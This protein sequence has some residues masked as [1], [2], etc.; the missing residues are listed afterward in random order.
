MQGVSTEKV[1]EAA[2]AFS[3][4]QGGVILVGVDPSGAPKGLSQPGEQERKLHHA[5]QGV[6]NCGRYETGQLTVGTKTILVVRIERRHEG[7]AQSSDG[8]V[9]LRRG[10]S[11]Q[12]LVGAELSRFVAANAFQAFEST[13]T[14]IPL[15]AVEAGL[16]DRLCHAQS[17]PA[18]DQLSTRLREEGFVA[19]VDGAERL[20]VAGALLLRKDPATI[21]CRAYVDIRRF[22][23]DLPE[24]DKTWEVRG[25]VPEQI[26]QAT[27]DIL[28]ELG[29][30]TAVLGPRRVDMPR[31]PPM[32][33]REA[34]ANA[35]AHRSYQHA[36]S[37]VRVEI[38]PDHVRITS[39]GGLP[40]PVTVENIRLQQA[41]RNSTLLGALRRMG[42]AE[43]LGL[44]IDRIE[45]QMASNLLE[46]PT[47][48]DD[49]SFFSITLR[50]S[51]TVTHLERAWILQL[52]DQQHLDPR[53]GPV[54]VQVARHGSITNAQVRKILGV[55]SVDARTILQRL[56][57]AGILEQRGQRGGAQ[58][59]LAPWAA[60][61]VRV[62]RAHEELEKIVLNLARQGPVTNSLVR[63]HAHLDRTE[64]LNLLRSLVAKGRLVREGSRRGAR[65]RLP[66]RPR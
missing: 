17:R 42:L 18:D 65:Y 51:G 55:D 50:F 14:A 63:E 2:V 22:G 7:F 1:Q 37:V 13:P 25:T 39:P 60:A 30:T 41:A 20:T 43:D 6:R 12:A 48:E 61:P 38:H 40:E 19:M 26:E 53:S 47:F 64:A 52:I 23:A 24:P 21:G 31:L 66:R 27:K 15:H 4:A 36:G 33:V 62:H 29:S 11:N 57:C 34:V 44:G 9:L 46:A 58:Y 10:A 16:L 3:N 54:V 49:G 28:A 45:D 5:L 59:V 8:R 32:V 35:V 56:V